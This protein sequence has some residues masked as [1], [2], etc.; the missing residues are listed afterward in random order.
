VPGYDQQVYM[1][2]IIVVAMLIQYG[3]GSLKR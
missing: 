3:A 1:G 2:L